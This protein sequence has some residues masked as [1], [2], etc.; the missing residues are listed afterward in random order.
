MEL[1]DNFIYDKDWKVR[2]ISQYPKILK[3]YNIYPQK[4]E[5]IIIEF[6]E[7]LCKNN[8]NEIDDIIKNYFQTTIYKETINELKFKIINILLD[9][10]HYENLKKYNILID[11]INEENCDNF[12]KLKEDNLEY[13][14][15]N[16]K[17]CYDIVGN[18]CSDFT[19][20]NNVCFCNSYKKK[21][22]KYKNKY[23]KLKNSI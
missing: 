4:K 17:C 6:L 22:V 20:E 2:L 11:T 3:L 23:I 9:Y 15:F 21:Y 18:K 13:G 14:L 5:I 7:Y 19:I 10:Y 16:S 12:Y 1:L 8:V